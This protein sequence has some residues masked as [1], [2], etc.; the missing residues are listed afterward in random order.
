[1][2]KKE[3]I[4][5]RHT[6]P[7]GGKGVLSERIKADGTIEGIKVKFYIGQEL[8]LKVMPYIRHIGNKVEYPITVV[9]NGGK[10]LTGDDDNFSF[11]VVIPVKNDDEFVVEFE[12]TSDYEYNLVVDVIVDYYGGQNRIVGGMVY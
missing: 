6:I 4:A 12:N 5:F 11:E 3:V 1:M 10:W 2:N 8:Y 7:P 9:G